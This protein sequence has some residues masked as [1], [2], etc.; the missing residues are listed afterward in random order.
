MLENPD[1]LRKMVEQSGAHGTNEESEESVEH[2]CAKCDEYAKKW[3]MVADEI[4]RSQPHNKKAY[5]NYAKE[6]RIDAKVL[7]QT[8]DAPVEVTYDTSARKVSGS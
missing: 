2:L 5:E 1:I 4:W 7:S 3:G 8:T 6:N